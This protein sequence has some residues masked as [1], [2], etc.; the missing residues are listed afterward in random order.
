MVSDQKNGDA[1][2]DAIVNNVLK[3]DILAKYVVARC[4]LRDGGVVE[5]ERRAKSSGGETAKATDLE[6]QRYLAR[7]VFDDEKWEF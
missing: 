4:V 7:F 5:L 2:F 3:N 1:V 6:A